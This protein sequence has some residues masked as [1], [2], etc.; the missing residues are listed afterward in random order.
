MEEKTVRLYTRQ[1][2]KTVSQLERNGRIKTRR[3]FIIK[4]QLIKDIPVQ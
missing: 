4:K 2:D 1:N 3:F